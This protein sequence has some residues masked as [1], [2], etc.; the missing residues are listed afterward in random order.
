MARAEQAR[1]TPLTRISALKLLLRSKLKLST[2]TS[3]LHKHI[4]ALTPNEARECVLLFLSTWIT[5][6][7]QAPVIQVFLE[8]IVKVHESAC[9]PLL[10]FPVLAW[11][12]GRP[13]S[14]TSSAIVASKLA[15]WHFALQGLHT[16]LTEEQRYFVV[17]STWHL[18][19]ACPN[20]DEHVKSTYTKLVRSFPEMFKRSR[21]EAVAILWMLV[22]FVVEEAFNP[23]KV[24]GFPPSCTVVVDGISDMFTGWMPGENYPTNGICSPPEYFT[25]ETVRCI[26]ANLS[27]PAS[28][29]QIVDGEAWNEVYG[30]N[31]HGLELLLERLTTPVTIGK[32]KTV[33]IETATANFV[34][35]SPISNVILPRIMTRFCSLRPTSVVVNWQIAFLRGLRDA[36]QFTQ[37]ASSLHQLVRS[38]TRWL[39]FYT[40]I[41]YPPLVESATTLLIA[42]LL[43]YQRNRQL[44]DYCVHAIQVV[45]ESRIDVQERLV[46]QM[47]AETFADVLSPSNA[48]SVRLICMLVLILRLKL[49]T[50]PTGI[51]DLITSA[52]GKEA[53]LK[54]RQN[55]LHLLETLEP[56]EQVLEDYKL[57]GPEHDVPDFGDSYSTASAAYQ[58]TRVAA[59]K[60]WGVTG[61]NNM[62]NMCFM[63]SCIQALY[64]TPLFR[65]AILSAPFI[66]GD[67]VAGQWNQCRTLRALGELFG[68]MKLTPQLS[69]DM[70]GLEEVLPEMFRDRRQHD[71]SEFGRFLLQTLEAEVASKYTD[72]PLLRQLL[73]C[74]T[75]AFTLATR[76]CSCNHTS[77]RSEN[78]V[79]LDL[80][81]TTPDCLGSLHPFTVES[82]MQH[83]MCS[84]E[85]LDGDDKYD[86]DVC[87]SK[88]PAYRTT[89]VSTLPQNLM[90]I[91]GR[92]QYDR[93]QT[94]K[95][96]TPV[97]V[98]TYL[99]LDQIYPDSD[100]EDR[101]ACYELHAMVVHVGQSAQ[102]GHYYC[103]AKVEEDGDS[104]GSA[105]W[106][107]LNDSVATKLSEQ[108]M[109]VMLE[110]T[111][112]ERVETPY[113][114]FYHR[115]DSRAARPRTTP[116]LT[117]AQWFRDKVEK[118]SAAAVPGL[119][120]SSSSRSR[121]VE[122]NTIWS[123]PN[124]PDD[125]DDSGSDRGLD[126]PR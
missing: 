27:R 3:L 12:L 87:Q 111:A 115:Q 22:K 23:E 29:A 40:A 45:L 32:D 62:G 63:I 13:N 35:A 52:A 116:L 31:P 9:S 56:G 34:S 20:P 33:P 119:S 42:V 25:R 70:R 124:N 15:V 114:L 48:I 94:K 5:S 66:H 47:R 50:K 95:I 89:K 21:D 76:C 1:H 6:G 44:A 57:L 58:S 98:P 43:G 96:S 86:C 4:D 91:L 72:G 99:D 68:R 105:G 88:Q 67:T 18:C 74:F 81:L 108:S 46:Q 53:M 73:S 82:L 101:G 80:R 84:T 2:T 112:V 102:Y 123:R 16:T 71:A 11:Y 110:Q 37:L 55:C 85:K 121:A 120:A 10:T 75:G 118:E 104:K 93:A 36:R 103:V 97:P 69:I 7:T 122:A 113:I 78:F 30:H 117:D 59:R 26:F 100:L 28:V 92:L 77:T 83:T 54:L 65:H 14:P 126:G 90:L 17:S 19:K 106:Y 64:N 8:H 107:K 51:V 38:T 61:I 49:G 125:D 60:E 39:Q 24:L 109:N 41:P 79:G